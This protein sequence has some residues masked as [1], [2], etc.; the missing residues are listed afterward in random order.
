[1]SLLNESQKNAFL[2]KCYKTEEYFD[3]DIADLEV[4]PENDNQYDNEDIVVCSW[5]SPHEDM[6][7]DHEDIYVFKVLDKQDRS[8]FVYTRPDGSISGLEINVGE[9]YAF[10]FN[11][12]HALLPLYLAKKVFEKQSFDIPEV[13][14]FNNERNKEGYKEKAKMAFYFIPVSGSTFSL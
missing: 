14:D 11:L 8:G 1:M 10:N 7:T 12:T 2:K 6:E 3:G 13:Y 9:T 4:M 5:L